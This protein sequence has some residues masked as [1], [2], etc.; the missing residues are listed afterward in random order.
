[1]YWKVRNISI[2]LI[3]VFGFFQKMFFSKMTQIFFEADF[4]IYGLFCILKWKSTLIS[5]HPFNNLQL[6]LNFDWKW[7]KKSILF[8]FSCFRAHFEDF[9]RFFFYFCFWKNFNWNSND[10]LKIWFCEFQDVDFELKFFEKFLFHHFVFFVCLEKKKKITKLKNHQNFMASF[11]SLFEILNDLVICFFFFSFQEFWFC[12]FIFFPTFDF[13]IAYFF[14][15]CFFPFFE[16]IFWIFK[17]LIDVE[18]LFWISNH[19]CN[20]NLFRSSNFMVFYFLFFFCL[21]VDNHFRSK[22]KNWSFQLLILTSS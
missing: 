16:W 11:N 17:V 13:K 18:F 20:R 3:H 6:Y 12:L 19:G 7:T 8:E 10:W 1:M 15:C 22:L 2:Q 4:D 5:N 9:F 21:F 14:F